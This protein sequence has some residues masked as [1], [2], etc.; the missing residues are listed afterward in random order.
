MAKH[1]FLEP[2]V[3]RAKRLAPVAWRIEAWTLAMFFWLL[4]RL[5]PQRAP[6]LEDRIPRRE[7]GDDRA[8]GREHFRQ[9]RCRGR[10]ARPHAAPVARA[11]AALRVRDGTRRN[12]H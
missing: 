11:R 12:V 8:L 6:K 4:G 9:P 10:R 1:Y 5:S 2:L 7:R 3:K